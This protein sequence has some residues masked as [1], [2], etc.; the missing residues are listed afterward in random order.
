MGPDMIGLV[1]DLVKFVPPAKMFDKH[2]FSLD[3]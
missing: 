2:V 1:P 3:R